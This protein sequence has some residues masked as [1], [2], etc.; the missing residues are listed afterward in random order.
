MPS[1]IYEHTAQRHRGRRRS[2]NKPAAQA[3]CGGHIWHANATWSPD[4]QLITF[5]DASF[6]PGAHEPIWVMRPDGTACGRIPSTL[7]GPNAA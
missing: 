2:D 7:L 1:I 3:S 5:N 4:G 6:K